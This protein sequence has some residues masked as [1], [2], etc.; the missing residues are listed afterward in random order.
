MDITT[1]AHDICPHCHSFIDA[2]KYLLSKD[3]MTIKPC[4]NCGREIKITAQMLYW[5]EPLPHQK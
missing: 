2:E 4:E 5:I 1:G 3:E